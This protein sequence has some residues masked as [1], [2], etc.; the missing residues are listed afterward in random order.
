MSKVNDLI[1]KSN[2]IINESKNVFLEE[3][4]KIYDQGQTVKGVNWKTFI[5]DEK[6]I[7]FLDTDIH[8]LNLKRVYDHPEYRDKTFW[9]L[10]NNDRTLLTLSNKITDIIGR[11]LNEPDLQVL[12]WDHLTIPSKM[13][14]K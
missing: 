13:E 9:I 8:Y 5:I 4:D 10:D 12:S 7:N 2:N 6:D 1:H 3:D 14:V 11:E